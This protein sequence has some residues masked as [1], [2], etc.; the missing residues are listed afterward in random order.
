MVGS[1]I[2][3][4]YHRDIYSSCGDVFCMAVALLSALARFADEHIVQSLM[5]SVL[6]LPD[7]PALMRVYG[8]GM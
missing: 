1:A 3:A 5:R 7:K 8:K 4:R 6:F 2:G